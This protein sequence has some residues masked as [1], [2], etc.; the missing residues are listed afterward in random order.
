MVFPV[1]RLADNRVPGV[2]AGVAINDP[3]K[4][5]V[6]CHD[7][8]EERLQILE[9]VI[10]HLRSDSEAKRQE[11]REALDKALQ[12]VEVMGH[13]HTLDEEESV[14]PRILAS[15]GEDTPILQELTTMLESQHREKEAVLEKLKAHV[16]AFPAA[17]APPS[18]EQAGQFEGLVAQLTG[19]YRP[20]IMI[21]N[22]RLI[23]LSAD[24]LNPNDA[25]QIRQEMRARR[26]A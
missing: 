4:H 3:L 19:L 23:P 2:D 26:G 5:L 6:A 7:R 8:I 11:A 13:L 1:S 10:P 20:H 24:H 14:F 15:G 12:F 18:A 25:E 21:E 16:A 22:E 17:P 9:R